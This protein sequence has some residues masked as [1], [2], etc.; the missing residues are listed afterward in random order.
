MG[1]RGQLATP[2]DSTVEGGPGLVLDNVLDSVPEGALGSQ[3]VHVDLGAARAVFS[4]LLYTSISS[5][6]SLV[7]TY[8]EIFLDSACF[9]F[10]EYV[11]GGGEYWQSQRTGS[12]CQ[13][14]QSRLSR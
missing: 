5:V 1:T 14:S 4:V 11:Q 13:S 12:S 8:T 3:L 10:L 2:S 9:Y 6:L 7:Y